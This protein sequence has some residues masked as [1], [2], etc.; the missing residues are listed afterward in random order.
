MRSVLLPSLLDPLFWLIVWVTIRFARRLPKWS[1]LKLPVLALFFLS[2]ASVI[3]LQSRFWEHLVSVGSDRGVFGA[4]VL[5][6]ELVIGIVLILWRISVEDK[7]PKLG[8]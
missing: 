8:R 6:P 5:E 4:R 1:L 3:V 2:S 7:R